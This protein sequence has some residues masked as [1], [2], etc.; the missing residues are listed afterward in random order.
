[1]RD[2]APERQLAAVGT[3]P[4]R[5]PVPS[6]SAAPAPTPPWVPRLGDAMRMFLGE[7]AHAFASEAW[8]FMVSGLSMQA[9]DTA[10]REGRGGLASGLG[11]AGG[12]SAAGEGALGEEA[13]DN[14]QPSRELDLEVEAGWREGRE[15]GEGESGDDEEVEEEETDGGGCFG[16]AL[17]PEG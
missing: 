13:A 6:D 12:E 14:S 17:A 5:Q 10:A 8:R 15:K 11:S 9:Y 16:L 3:G 2:G 4:A 7:H 1:M